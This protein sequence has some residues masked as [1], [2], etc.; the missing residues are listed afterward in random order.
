M[1]QA[2]VATGVGIEPRQPNR[3][4]LCGATVPPDALGL[5]ECICG[6]GG[7][8]DPLEHDRGLAKVVAR[9]DRELADGQAHRDLRRLAM[10]GDAASSL[11]ILYLALLLFTSTVIYVAVLAVIALCVWLTISTVLDHTWIGAIVGC[12][13]LALIVGS[14]WPHRRGSGSIQV[15]RERFPSLMAAL[16]EVRQ[17]TG[18]RVPKHIM[19]WPGDDFSIGRRLAGGDVLHIGVM[20]LP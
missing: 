5:Y 2:N 12:I 8:D 1:D 13:L 19:L 6:W 10:R 17:R 4:P 15:T 14:L 3:C 7:P 18:V 16:D 9:I 11:N 20:N